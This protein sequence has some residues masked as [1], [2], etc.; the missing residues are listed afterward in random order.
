M[1]VAIIGSSKTIFYHSY[2]KL[3]EKAGHSVCKINSNPNVNCDTSF[4]YFFNEENDV[5]STGYGKVE[6]V[7]RAVRWFL[8]KIGIESSS[9]VQNIVEKRSNDSILSKEQSDRLYMHLSDFNPDVI[10]FFWGTTLKKEAKA[11]NNFNSK[12]LLI[13]NTYP[14]RTKFDSAQSNPFRTV[15]KD[16]FS[17]FDGLVLTSKSMFDFF[18]ESGFI[19]QNQ[20]VTINAD[21]IEMEI[22]E[23]SKTG[24]TS[25]SNKVIFL[26]NTDFCQRTLDDVSEHILDLAKSGIEVHIQS[27]GSLISHEN[28][29]EFTPFNFQ[30]IL[31]G[32]LSAFINR[33]DGV[34]YAYNDPSKLRYNMS[35]TTRL[36]LAESAL[37]PVYIYGEMPDSIRDNNLDLQA[38][39]YSTIDDLRNLIDSKKSKMELGR[40]QERKIR[41]LNFIESVYESYDD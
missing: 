23:E 35:I 5:V 33:F 18:S 3:L 9:L 24:L 38:Y 14:V 30:E 25:K 11:L 36:L 29:K 17:L 32:K 16:Y 4:N 22:V 12:K 6:I 41:F 40:Q 39:S 21:F 27:G 13:V 2:G 1:K 28:I 8:R 7:K 26:G 37:V 34:I 10:L 15:D 20:K 19:H 31:E